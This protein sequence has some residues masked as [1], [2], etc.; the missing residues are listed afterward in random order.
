MQL[1]R[2]N[3]SELSDAQLLSVVNR[4]LMVHHDAFLLPVLEAVVARPS[5]LE[6]VDRERVYQ[7]LV[8]LHFRHGELSKALD[9]ARVAREKLLDSHATFEQQWTWDLRELMLRLTD[10]ADAELSPLLQKFATYYGPKIPQM[11]GYL[12]SILQE[13]GVESPWSG[14]GMIADSGSVW[15][16]EREPAA[17]G[18]GKLWL[19]GQ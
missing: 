10:P 12:E 13:A 9:W 18:A 2:V 1:H 11:R 15:T 16:P 5:C 17:A 3:A 4:A 14:P 8:D 7:T 19:P 6:Q